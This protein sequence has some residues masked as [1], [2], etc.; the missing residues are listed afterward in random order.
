[1][2]TRILLAEEIQ[3][4]YAKAIGATGALKAAI[5]QREV[6]PIINQVANEILGTVIQESVK[7]GDLIIPS[8]M[9]AT[10]NAVPVSTENGRSF[11]LM[12]VHPL[13]L[14][15]NMGVYSVVPQTGSSPLIDGVPFIPITQEDW[16]VLSPT[17]I[18]TTGLLEDQIAF[19]VEGRK[20]F[21]T[22]PP[23]A[24]VVKLKLAISDPALIGDN[25]PYPITPELE[26]ILVQRVLDILKG[27]TGRPQPAN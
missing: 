14:K 11:A 26:I 25:D 20:V 8:S 5:D 1:M 7:L 15:R 23:T 27:N 3:R 10:Y 22:K 19:Y 13:I 2:A 21:F 12:P 24:T 4:L 18:N 17:D 9:I 6:Y 16:D